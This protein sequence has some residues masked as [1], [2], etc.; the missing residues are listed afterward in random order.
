MP[1]FIFGLCKLFH[2]SICLSFHVLINVGLYYVLKSG[3]MSP[4]ALVF[5]KIVLTI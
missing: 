4:P 2:W 5:L 3:N 1:G